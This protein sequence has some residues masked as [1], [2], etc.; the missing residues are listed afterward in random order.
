MRVALRGGRSIALGYLEQW[1]TYEGVLC[2]RPNSR[3]N[4]RFV[5]SALDKARERDPYGAEPFLL[6]P[7]AGD[8]LL[9]VTCIARFDSSQLARPGSEP[10]SSLTVVWFQEEFGMP[11]AGRVLE[12]LSAL[13]WEVL[14][15]D[16][17]W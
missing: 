10:Y 9:R 15:A 5:V 12:Q 1:P 11:G 16:W 14:A 17:C 4:E 2:G 8:L 7:P 6:A 3:I 13:E